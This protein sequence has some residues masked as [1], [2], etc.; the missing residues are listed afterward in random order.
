[1]SFYGK[2]FFAGSRKAANDNA[3]VMRKIFEAGDNPY[4]SWKPAADIFE[5]DDGVVV[6]LELPGIEPEDVEIRVAGDLL[7]LRGTKR[8]ACPRCKKSYR[9]ME[10][11]R[12]P[13]ERILPL[14]RTVDANRASAGLHGGIL[15]IFLPTSTEEVAGDTVVIEW[16][17][18]AA[19][20]RR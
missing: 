5:T 12:G 9:L 11:H 3:E 15:E 4:E 16:S 1:M 10:I 19:R 2:H 6:L 17:V 14:P 13:F 8:E 18:A 20:H 7:T